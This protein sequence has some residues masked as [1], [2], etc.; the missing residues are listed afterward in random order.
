MYHRLRT[1][2]EEVAGKPLTQQQKEIESAIKE[3]MQGN[4]ITDDMLLI[5]FQI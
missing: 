2:L 5:A 1:L 4:T 3:W